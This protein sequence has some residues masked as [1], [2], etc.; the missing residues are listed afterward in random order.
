[1]LKSCH[2][3]RRVQVVPVGSGVVE[4]PG[5]RVVAVPLAGGGI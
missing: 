4:G 3:A 2:S 5:L 1:M